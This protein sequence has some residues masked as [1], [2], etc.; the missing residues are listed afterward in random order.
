ML[1]EYYFLEC[2]I[3]QATSNSALLVFNKETVSVLD[4]RLSH[5]RFSLI[6]CSFQ[7]QNSIS[8]NMG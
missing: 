2:T 8:T 6:R 3:F 5:T 4:R 1:Y 7:R